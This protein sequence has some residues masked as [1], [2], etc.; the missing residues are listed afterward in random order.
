MI[1][2]PI[3]ASAKRILHRDGE[4]PFWGAYHRHRPHLDQ[5]GWH[6]WDWEGR[7]ALFGVSPPFPRFPSEAIGFSAV[8]THYCKYIACTVYGSDNTLCTHPGGPCRRFQK[9]RHPGAFNPSAPEAQN[10]R[11]RPGTKPPNSAGIS[12]ILAFAVISFPA[13]RKTSSNSCP[14]AAP[15]IIW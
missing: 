9:G 14:T 3:Q 6:R 8:R 1:C 12:A 2:N 5:A 15:V 4:P 13:R 7:E 11:Q 10:E